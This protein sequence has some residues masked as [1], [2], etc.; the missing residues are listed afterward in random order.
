ME[1]IETT[2]LYVGD[3][4]WFRAFKKPYKVRAT[5][6]RFAICTQPFNLRP[7]TVFYTIIDFERNVRGLENWVFSLYDYYLDDDC[8]SALQDL[9]NGEMEVSWRDHKHVALDIVRVK[10]VKQ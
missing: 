8:E 7:K 6:G 10:R 2:I 4:V 3:R 1:S 9:I 5:N